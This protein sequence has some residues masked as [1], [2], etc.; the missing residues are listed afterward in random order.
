MSNLTDAVTDLLSLEL[1][2]ENL[3]L[4]RIEGKRG[5]IAA[6]RELARQLGQIRELA[7][8]EQNLASDA[9]LTGEFQ[10]RLAKIR[11]S[12]ALHQAEW[13]A[14]T[15][16][17]SPTDYQRSAAGVGRAINEFVAWARSVFSDS[18]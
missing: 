10:R 15:S 2:V 9:V 5:L 1:R 18:F 7:E 16:N 8:H 17:D 13:P 11:T 12:A 4:S 3:D 14:V 6:R